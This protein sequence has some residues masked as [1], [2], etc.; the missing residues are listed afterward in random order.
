MTLKELEALDAKLAKE[1]SLDALFVRMMVWQSQRLTREIDRAE[2][3][4]QAER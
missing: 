3:S 2:S 4:A 1:S